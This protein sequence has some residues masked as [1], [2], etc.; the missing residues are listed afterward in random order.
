[1]FLIYLFLFFFAKWNVVVLAKNRRDLI[2][3]LKKKLASYIWRTPTVD[4]E[5]FIFT[6]FSWFFL[7]HVTVRNV[8][9]TVFSMTHNL[10][11]SNAHLFIFF[12]LCFSILFVVNNFTQDIRGYILFC[13]CGVFFFLILAAYIDFISFECWFSFVRFKFCY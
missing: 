13:V 10:C 2:K 5:T 1:M 3:W 8:F 11:L 9:R 7:F 4:I 12:F 6:T